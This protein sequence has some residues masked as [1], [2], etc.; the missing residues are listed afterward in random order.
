[1]TWL[2]AR[3]S[4][5]GLVLLAVSLGAPSSPVAAQSSPAA[6]PSPAPPAAAVRTRPQK[7]AYGTV[8]AIDKSLSAVAMKTNDGKKL[9]WR[10]PPRV[11]EQV[12]TNFKVGDQMIVIYRQI[13]SSE[14]RVTA[15]AFPGSA[16][17][18]IYVNTTGSRVLVRTSPMVNGVCGT[19]DAGPISES[20]L[21]ADGLAEVQEACWCCAVD[22]ES[23]TPGNKSG[24]GRAF[25]VNCFK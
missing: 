24:N 22:G 4:A 20:M 8:S 3:A 19:P 6:T 1:M 5:G 12:A 9:A 11:I 23:C 18:P 15:V 21:P 10:F 17:T 13:S 7:S 25:L 16:P 14:K 2:R